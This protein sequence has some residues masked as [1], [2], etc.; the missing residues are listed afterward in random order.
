MVLQTEAKSLNT[1]SLVENEI[2][3]L[4]AQI[5]IFDN[6]GADRIEWIPH[7]MRY[8]SIYHLQKLLLAHQS[9]DLH[10]VRHFVDHI[11]VI[12]LQI[13]C[14][15]LHFYLE[16]YCVKHKIVVKLYVAWGRALNEDFVL[17]LL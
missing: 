14:D 15:F 9:L 11:D 3:Y 6:H 12:I 4:V 13:K 2:E 8:Q 10:R 5:H 17:K 1:H 7:L 16:K